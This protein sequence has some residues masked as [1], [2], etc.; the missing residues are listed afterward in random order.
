ML[1]MF[2]DKAARGRLW[3]RIDRPLLYVIG[4]QPAIWTFYLA[5]TDQ[6]GADPVKSL[7]HTLGIWAFR[8]LIAALLVSPLRGLGGPNLIRYRRA[9]GLLCFYYAALHLTAYLVFDQGLDAA[10]IWRDIY[11]RWFITIGMASFVLLVPLALTS[12]N[13]AIRKLGGKAW[14]RLHRLVYI[15]AIGVSAHFILS[16]KSWPAEPLIYAGIVAILLGYRLARAIPGW[17]RRLSAPKS[18]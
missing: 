6:L 3:R 17:T 8:F 2:G 1:A 11:K 12:T 18:A 7:E 13:A 14:N 16:V 10:A 4:L 9:L 15:A 5:F